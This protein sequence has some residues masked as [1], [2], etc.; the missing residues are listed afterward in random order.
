[1]PAVSPY[2]D[3]RIFDAVRRLVLQA[4]WVVDGPLVGENRSPFHGFSVE[5]KQHREYVQGD[6]LRFLDWRVF[7]RSDRYVIKQYEQF[8][9]YHGHILLDVSESMNFG[10]QE[11]T[12]LQ[13]AKLMAVSLAFLIINTR[14]AVGLGVFDRELRQFIAPSGSMNQIQRFAAACDTHDGKRKTNVGAILEEYASRARRRGIIIVLSDFF[15]SVENIISGLEHLRFIGHE[16]ILLH[17]LDPHEREFPYDGL[18]KFEGLE[19][20]PEL[21]CRPKELRVTYL[22]KLDAFCGA[23]QLG[24]ERVG[25]DFVPVTTNVPVETALAEY[26]AG[27][28][29]LLKR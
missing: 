17:V 5:F 28:N 4:R 27:R 16:V 23:L 8:S 7:A 13:Y 21:L 3:T 11:T 12:K 25:C 20:Y 14:D 18:I 1:M 2:I 6:D 26:L 29:R 15:D 19:Q 9:N 22:E 10:S 24:C